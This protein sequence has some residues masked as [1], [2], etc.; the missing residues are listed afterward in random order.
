MQIEV[1]GG[2]ARPPKPIDRR[3]AKRCSRWSS[4]PAPTSASTIALAADRRRVRRQQH[5]RLRRAG[6]RHDGRAR[7]RDP[8]AG[9]ISDRRQPR[10][11]ARR[12]S[13]L[14]VLRIAEEGDHE[15]SYPR[16]ATRAIFEPL[17]EMAKLTG[18]GFTN[19]PPDRARARAPSST[20]PTQA[21]ARDDRRHRRRAVRARARECRR[22]AMSAAPARCSARS[23]ATGPSTATASA[24]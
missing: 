18:G 1:H 10:P 8:F 12:L 3:R 11:S 20:Q 4:R 16:R 22:P 13:A 7:R 6:G 23:A 19:L 15:L 21:F 5:R 17:Y 2:F 9:R 14:T 24:R